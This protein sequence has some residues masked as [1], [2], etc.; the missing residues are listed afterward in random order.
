MVILGTSALAGLVGTRLALDRDT[1][2]ASDGVGPA[3]VF[4]VAV[5]V[6]AIVLVPAFVVAGV[7]GVAV[8]AV[9]VVAVVAATPFPCRARMSV[10]GTGGSLRP[11][12]GEGL[13]GETPRATGAAGRATDGSMRRR[14]RVLRSGPNIT[15]VS[16]LSL[17]LCAAIASG[18]A[19]F[20]E[21][22]R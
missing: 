10:V 4:V 9:F 17:V 16:K 1:G 21:K 5:I 19:L 13:N 6:G 20:C 22:A 11:P 2:G 12:P 8:V 3:A 18:S 14:E 7:A 15:E